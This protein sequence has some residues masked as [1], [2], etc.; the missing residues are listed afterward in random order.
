V[1]EYRP[2]PLDSSEAMNIFV[3]A[4]M[5]PC[6]EIAKLGTNV[7]VNG[8]LA[9]AGVS[10]GSRVSARLWLGW[11]LNAGAL[12]LEPVQPAP[13]AFVFFAHGLVDDKRDPAER[14]GSLVLPEAGGV[15]Q[16]E[17]SRELLYPLLGVPL[18]A[19]EL[20]S[21]VAGC[22]SFG[23]GMSGHTLGPNVVRVLLDDVI[24]GD[25]LFRRDA[26]VTAGWTL[27]GMGRS[28][29]GTTSQWRAHYGRRVLHVFRD[30]R[31]RSQEWNGVMD[32]TFNV[33]FSWRRIQAGPPLDK[34]LF[35]PEPLGRRPE[36]S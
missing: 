12:R 15:I 7:A 30:F 13:P 22:P 20:T 31:I 18:S 10:N 21:V 9:V 19:H 26:S 34:E 24:P 3:E 16:T 23:G 33:S 14:D 25:F 5:R 8:E 6:A 28:M 17:R 2:T 35:V 29:P 1:R 27:V 36:D 4:A 11:D 32:R